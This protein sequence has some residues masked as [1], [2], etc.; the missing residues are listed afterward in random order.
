MLN[1]KNQTALVTGASGGIGLEICRLLYARGMNLVLVSRSGE[2]LKEVKRTLEAGPG[3]QVFVLPADLSKPGEAERLYKE[4]KALNINVDVLI[5]NAGSGLFGRALELGA[6]KTEA[7]LY[8]NMNSLAALCL[9]YGRDMAER[10]GGSILNIGS[11]VALMPIPYFSAYAASKS[12][13]RSFS[14]SLRQELKAAHVRVS[15]LMPGY[16]RTNFDSAAGVQSESYKKMSESLAQGPEAVAKQA[17]SL[18]KSGQAI[19]ISGLLNR[20]AAFLLFFIP[21]G[22]LAPLLGGNLKKKL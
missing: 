9:L 2:K 15:C 1:L 14:L 19:R 7:M 4:T 13:V 17:V 8:L 21:D 20:I 3:G 22:L 12:F 5:N 16:V 10:G 6:E 11:L 18:I